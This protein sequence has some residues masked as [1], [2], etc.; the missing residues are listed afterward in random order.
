MG[1]EEETRAGKLKQRFWDPIGMR[2]QSS[3]EAEQG[4]PTGVGACVARRKHEVRSWAEKQNPMPEGTT[5][6]KSTVEARSSIQDE[7]RDQNT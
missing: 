3:N 4:R 7:Q 1:E 6:P 2:R 5:H